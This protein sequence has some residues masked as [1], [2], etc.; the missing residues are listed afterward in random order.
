MRKDKSNM[1]RNLKL[2]LMIL[3][4]R[5]LNNRMNYKNKKNL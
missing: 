4:K 2:I 5:K 3:I 1:N